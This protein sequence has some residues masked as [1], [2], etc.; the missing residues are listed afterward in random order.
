MTGPV[1]CNKASLTPSAV[2]PV[3][4]QRGGGRSQD[5]TLP[6]PCSQNP[7]LR[8][9][10]PR[11]PVSTLSVWCFIIATGHTD[12]VTSAR[13]RPTMSLSLVL[14]TAGSP[15]DLGQVLPSFWN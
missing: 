10:E 11:R 5:T 6:L 8:P 7:R 12:T 1:P 14:G 9:R 15:G 3:R 13:R 4:T 2:C